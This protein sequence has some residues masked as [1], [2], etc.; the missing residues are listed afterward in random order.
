M[1]EGEIPFYASIG[2][3]LSPSLRSPAADGLSPPSPK[4]ILDA[5]GAE[6]AVE[7]SPAVEEDRAAP[8]YP[9]LDKSSGFASF[10]CCHYRGG[11]CR[12]VA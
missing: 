7:A 1:C 8:P 12:I 9:A 3:H 11:E 2:A 4:P 6:A 5:K 10:L